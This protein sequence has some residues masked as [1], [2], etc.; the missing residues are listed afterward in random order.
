MK[1]L[2]L[3]PFLIGGGRDDGYRGATV[4]SGWGVSARVLRCKSL[5]VPFILIGGVNNDGDRGLL[6][7]LAGELLLN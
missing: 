2:A 1:R 6:R 5:G 3:S 7:R 4:P